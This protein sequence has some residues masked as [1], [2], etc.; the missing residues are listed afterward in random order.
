MT[1]LSRSVQRLEASQTLILTQRARIMRESGIDVIS[2]TA[3]E[4][5]F[6]TPDHIKEAAIRAIRENHSYYTA[7][8]GTA[9]VID[10]VIRKFGVENNLRFEPSQILV[11]TGGKQSIFNALCAILNPGDEALI[12]SPYYV[13]YPSMVKLAGGTPRIVRLSEE[14]GYRPDV[15]LLRAALTPNTRLLILNTPV[16]P[17]GNV[18]TEEETEGLARFVRSTG[19]T[20]ISDEVYEKILFDGRKHVSIGSFDGMQDHVVTVNSLSKTYAMTGWRLGYMGGPKEIIQAAAKVQG[21]ITNN[22][23]AIAQEA[24]RAALLGSSAE[25]SLMVNEYA[26]RRALVAAYF[27]R[28]PGVRFHPPEGAFY[29]FVSLQGYTG[30][31]TKAG[32]P[33]ATSEEIVDYLLDTHHVAVVGGA[34]FGAPGCIRLS[35]S[36]DE[37]RLE[38]GLERIVRGIEELR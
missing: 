14:N 17:T 25:T 37:R 1:H 19:L 34:A 29:A 11:S 20:V 22:A 21:Q 4:P 12:L 8:Q 10:A 32:K 31:A 36:C 28:L 15:G 2:L 24:A 9:A 3:G 33:L 5:H 13:S 27:A 38:Q 6:P 18:F 23:N 7:N 35:F 26:K 30:R 16:N